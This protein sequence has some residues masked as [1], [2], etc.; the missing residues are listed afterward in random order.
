MSLCR[1][2][3]FTSVNKHLRNAQPHK[4]EEGKRSKCKVFLNKCECIRDIRTTRFR[5]EKRGAI[6]MLRVRLKGR[7]NPIPPLK[8]PIL[9]SPLGVIAARRKFQCIRWLQ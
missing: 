4:V 6:R 3:P 7:M 8:C 9:F 1:V 2:R 5:G